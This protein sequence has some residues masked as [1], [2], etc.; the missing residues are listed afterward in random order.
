MNMEEKTM[1]NLRIARMDE[2]DCVCTFFDEVI[3]ALEGA[4][5]SPG[6]EKDIYPDRAM[7]EGFVQRGEMYV[8]EAEGKIACAV[9]LNQSAQHENC[10]EIHLLAVHPDFRGRTLGKAMVEFAVEAARQKAMACIRLDVT[11]G[12]L[13]AE[14]LYTGMGFEFEKSRRDWFT[15]EEYM[16]F[17]EFSYMIK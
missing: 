5:Y 14:K 10:M 15:E 2:L 1:L 16:D 13:P 3:D 17:R 8:G 7:L 6:W 9:A 11:E 12:N 4:Q